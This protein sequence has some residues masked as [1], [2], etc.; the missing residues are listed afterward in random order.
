MSARRLLKGARRTAGLSQRELAS[1]A[2]V[3]QSTVARIELGSLSPRFNTL[4]QLLGAMGRTLAVETRPGQGLDR[5]LIREF[6]RLTPAE[7]VRRLTADARTIRLLDRAAPH[8][9]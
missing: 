1:K 5:T 4:E 3:P 6:L 7:R 2:G 9:R 8:V